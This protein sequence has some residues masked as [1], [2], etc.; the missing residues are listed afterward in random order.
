[1]RKVSN[2][3]SS[4]SFNLESFT[5][6]WDSEMPITEMAWPYEVRCSN[7]AWLAP[8]FLGEEWHY[9]ISHKSDFYE[10]SCVSRRSSTA[11]D[12]DSQNIGKVCLKFSEN[13][14]N[15]KTT[16]SVTK[17]QALTLIG[18]HHGGLGFRLSASIQSRST[19]C[20]AE[21][22]RVRRRLFPIE[23]CVASFNVLETTE[24]STKAPIK[25]QFIY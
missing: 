7:M 10:Y 19:A 11:I 20:S 17:S 18:C 3:S 14:G 9:Y 12:G 13:C 6:N 5:T 22:E 23:L 4:G 15:M 24:S 1:M 21:A 16:H 8:R 2:T 25:K